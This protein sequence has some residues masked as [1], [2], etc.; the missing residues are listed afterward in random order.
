MQQAEKMRCALRTAFFQ[1]D[2]RRLLF[3]YLQRMILVAK[4]NQRI[5]RVDY[6]PVILFYSLSSEYIDNDISK[7]K[8]LASIVKSA[9]ELMY[10]KYRSR[11]VLELLGE[12][13][14][15]IPIEIRMIKKELEAF[16]LK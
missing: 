7:E 9:R 6:L 12:L 14:K 1:V 5:D 13:A 3:L 8:L 11:K 10:N 16:I 15:S 2:V 4:E